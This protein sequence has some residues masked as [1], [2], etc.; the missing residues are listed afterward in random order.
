MAMNGWIYFSR[1]SNDV[2]LNRALYPKNILLRRPYISLYVAARV[3]G[4][5][6]GTGPS[7]QAQTGL[8]VTYVHWLLLTRMF[9]PLKF[10]P[11]F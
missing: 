3:K 2:T 4:D 6:A 7:L 9:C 8:T 10:E 11:F 5:S 1:V